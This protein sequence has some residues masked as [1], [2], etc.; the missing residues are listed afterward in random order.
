VIPL[1]TRLEMDPVV[2]N[3]FVALQSKNAEARLMAIKPLCEKMG[4]NPPEVVNAIFAVM[5]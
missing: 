1:A 5:R 3:S 2:M 4:I